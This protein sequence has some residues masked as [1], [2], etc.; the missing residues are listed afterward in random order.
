M[1][2]THLRRGDLLHQNPSQALAN[3]SKLPC[4]V[5]IDTA[6]LYALWTNCLQRCHHCDLCCR[7]K[8]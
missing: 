2:Q 7:S 5:A 3:P 6:A 8:G 4:L 1:A